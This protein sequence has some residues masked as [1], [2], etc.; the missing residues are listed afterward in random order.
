MQQLIIQEGLPVTG[1]VAANPT[2]EVDR[3][4]SGP[5]WDTNR[6]PL[7]THPRGE[8]RPVILRM[9]VPVAIQVVSA[10]P[11]WERVGLL[12]HLPEAEV[13][14]LTVAVLEVEDSREGEAEEFQEE[15]VEALL[16]EGAGGIDEL[17]R[18]M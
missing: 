16:V 9:D 10:I 15:A 14:D 6:H 7:D 1:W 8:F 12:V 3:V 13:S 11:G 17:I 18:M 2:S 5:R 4:V